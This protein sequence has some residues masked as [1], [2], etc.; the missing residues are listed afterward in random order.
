MNKFLTNIEV[1]YDELK[2]DDLSPMGLKTFKVFIPVFEE[3][4]IEN[5]EKYSKMTLIQFSESVNK[6]IEDEFL[7]NKEFIDVEFGIYGIELEEC[8]KR[9][10][11][12]LSIEHLKNGVSL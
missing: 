12:R 10:F 1:L 3:I 6:M 5:P 9:I 11:I 2:E 4:L 7:K 8:Y